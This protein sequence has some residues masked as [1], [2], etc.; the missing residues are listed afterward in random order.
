[1]SGQ[2]FLERTEKLVEEQAKRERSNIKA[3][4]ERF[5]PAPWMAETMPAK[6]QDAAFATLHDDA[7]FWTQAVLVE[8]KIARLSDGLGP[9]E[10]IMDAIAREKRRRGGKA[11][12]AAPAQDAPPGHHVMPDGALMADE[13]MA[14]PDGQG[15]AAY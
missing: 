5:G 10:L 8:G 11:A 15:G 6:E 14:E 9:R 2:S 3:M 4:R 1:M 12:P 13:E 7:E